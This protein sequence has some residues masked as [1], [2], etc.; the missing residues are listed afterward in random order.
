M[1]SKPA[2]PKAFAILVVRG[3]VRI[4]VATHNVGG[5]VFTS[6]CRHY[7]VAI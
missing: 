4:H 5:W 7:L 3:H 6:T 2:R 1:A